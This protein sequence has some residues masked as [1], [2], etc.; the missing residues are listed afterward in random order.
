VN[1]TSKTTSP[2][3]IR[4]GPTRPADTPGSEREEGG[5]VHDDFGDYDPAEI[6][7]GYDPRLI[8]Y[9][10]FDED[11]G[12]VATDVSGNGNNGTVQSATTGQAGTL[13]TTAYSCGGT[14]TPGDRVEVPDGSE[15]TVTL[16]V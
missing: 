14:A 11:S 10:P 15:K 13:N 9:W 6:E 5:V 8:A 16:N 7:L 4:C 3:G 1:S 12:T 2:T